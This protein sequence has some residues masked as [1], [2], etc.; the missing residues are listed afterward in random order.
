MRFNPKMLSLL[1][2]LALLLLAVLA[3]AFEQGLLATLAGAGAVV[4]G[5]L[6]LLPGDRTASP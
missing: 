4:L 1:G 2:A 6:A 5:L 3:L